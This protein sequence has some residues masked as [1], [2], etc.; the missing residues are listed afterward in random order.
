MGQVVLKQ[1]IQEEF[2]FNNLLKV[3]Y[4]KK[5]KNV[6]KYFSF[7]NFQIRSF[8]KINCNPNLSPSKCWYLSRLNG[9]IPFNENQFSKK[10]NV[11]DFFCGAGGFSL[12]LKEACENLGFKTNFLLA[13]DKDKYSKLVYE[14]NFNPNKFLSSDIRFFFDYQKS[15]DTTK[16][17]IHPEFNKLRNKIDVFLAGPPCEGNSN[18]NNKTRGNDPRNNLFLDT[19]E[20]AVHLNSK[21]ILFENVPQ[22]VANKQNVIQKSLDLLKRKNYQ[23]FQLKLKASDYGVAQSR[24]RFFLVAFKND[25]YLLEHQLKSLSTEIISSSECLAKDEIDGSNEFYKPSNLSAKNSD[26]VKFLHDN[27]LFNLPDNERPDCHRLKDHNYNAVYGRMYPNEPSP[28]ITT[29]F[30]SPGRGRFTHPLFSRSLTP[31]EGSRLQSFPYEFDWLT[32]DKRIDRSAW[33]RLIGGAVPPNLSYNLC[34]S[35]LV[36]SGFFQEILDEISNI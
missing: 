3:T 36:C 12:G 20:I 2:L 10:I 5:G 4:E 25:N 11:V 34:L 18:L 6:Y 24:R 32:K 16:I 8:M 35:S 28:T 30:L 13:L 1:D 23:Y 29:G 19:L 27:D 17:H 26:R 15:L 9:S 31:H 14:K 33:S 22:V 7:K 21:I